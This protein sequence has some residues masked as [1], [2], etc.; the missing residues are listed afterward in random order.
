MKTVSEILTLSTQY[1]EEKRVV[2]SRRMAEGLIAFVLGLK[3]IELYQQF[4]RPIVESEQERVRAGLKQLGKGC[5]LEY[6]L[7]EIEFFQCRIQVDARALIPRPE[8]EVLVD[9]IVK[10]MQGFSH[11]T[12]WD[13]CTGTGCIGISLKKQFPSWSISLSDIAKDA[14]ELASFNA[15]LNEAEVVCYEGDL[16]APFAGKKADLIVCN[17]PYVASHEYFTLDSSVRDYEPKIALV[18]G[19]LGTEF[20]ERLARELPEYLNPGARL[21]LEIGALQ[22]SALKQI[23][24]S[25]IW[26]KQEL[27]FDW[28]GRERFFFLEMQQL[29]RVSS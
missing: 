8:T 29:S 26:C 11:K 15:R 24:S 23:F 10:R 18:G 20:Y 14:L 17:P 22:G 27:C 7:G 1:L 3:R 16:L 9:H 4:D 21:F 12:L 5:P 25:P 6:I 13:L 19:S 28:S 2:R